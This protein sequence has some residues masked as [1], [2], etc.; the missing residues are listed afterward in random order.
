MKHL[1]N[2]DD[3]NIEYDCVVVG[4]GTAGVSCAY[5]SAQKLKVLVIE[6]ELSLGGSQTNGLVTPMMPSYTPRHTFHKI[7]L[8]NLE[9]HENCNLKPNRETKTIW[10]NPE[11]MQQIMLNMLIERNVDIMYNAQLIDVELNNN[12]IKAIIIQTFNHKIRIRAKN[13]VDASGDAWLARLCNI[14]TS[15][16]PKN[17]HSSLTLRFEMGNIDIP[18]LK[19]WCNELNYQFYD[20]ST[21]DNFFEFVHIFNNDKLGALKDVLRQGLV[22]NELD[23]NDLR[24]IQGFT[25]SGKSNVMSFNNPQ[26]PNKYCPTNVTHLSQAVTIGTLMQNKLAKFL[27]KHIPGFENS[28]ILKRAN[29]LGIRESYR[30]VGKYVMTENDYLNK[31]KFNDGIACGDWYIDVHSDYETQEINTKYAKGEYYQIPYRSLICSEVNNYIAIG[32]HI[33]TTF[34]M[35]AS[36]RIQV[37]CQD[38]GEAAALACI[39]SSEHKINLNQIDGKIIK[40]QLNLS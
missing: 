6:K 22:D 17:Q 23:E 3:Y 34:L 10:F 2:I 31:E 20:P 18:K 24:Y 15:K 38:M 40:K 28:Y 7:L 8:K 29:L 5:T 39:Y 36:T 14:K 33:S 13:F 30:I 11:S 12:D 32:R 9:K 35:Q 1:E 25:M 26:I 4:G 37:T 16:A 27:K 21:K 19:K